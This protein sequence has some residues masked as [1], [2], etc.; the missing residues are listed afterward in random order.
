M[1][2]CL[3]WQISAKS[4]GDGRPSSHSL[5]AKSF[6]TANDVFVGFVADSFDLF[7]NSNFSG[8]AAPKSPD[9]TFGLFLGLLKACGSCAELLLETIETFNWCDELPDKDGSWTKIFLNQAGCYSG[10]YL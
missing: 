10:R 6:R 5:V 9:E 8:N 1:C 3:S 7:V 4:T 2:R